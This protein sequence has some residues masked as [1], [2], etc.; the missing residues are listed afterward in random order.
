MLIYTDLCTLAYNRTAAGYCYL[1][2]KPKEFTFGR[3]RCRAI[4]PL[5]RFAVTYDTVIQ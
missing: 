5:N 1:S 3:I 2:R 4:L